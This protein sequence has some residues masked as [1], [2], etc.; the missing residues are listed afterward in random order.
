[1][2]VGLLTAIAWYALGKPF[3]WFRFFF[4]RHHRNDHAR[5]REPCDAGPVE[6]GK[7]TTFFSGDGKI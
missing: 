7:R 1:M 5:R 3:G 2:I 6:C 4:R